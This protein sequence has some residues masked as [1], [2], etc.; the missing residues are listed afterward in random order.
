MGLAV[1]LRQIT[2]R[3]VNTVITTVTRHVVRLFLK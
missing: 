3:I 1:T 2:T